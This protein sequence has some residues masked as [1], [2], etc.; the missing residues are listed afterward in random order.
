[1]LRAGPVKLRPAFRKR[2]IQSVVVVCVMKGSDQA[3]IDSRHIEK[4]WECRQQSKIALSV[5]R[6][7]KR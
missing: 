2:T 4:H 1:M 5:Q 6:L 3:V 7:H